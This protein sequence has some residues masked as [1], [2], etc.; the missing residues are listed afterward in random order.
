MQNIALKFF[1]LLFATVAVFF[2]GYAG[3]A[4]FTALQ[5]FGS[6]FIGLV[7]M[8]VAGILGALTSTPSTE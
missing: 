8:T 5:S 6:L 3:N 1:A 4:E 2:I 7:T